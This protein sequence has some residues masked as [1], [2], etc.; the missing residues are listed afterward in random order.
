MTVSYAVDRALWG[1]SSFG[2]HLT[3]F[4]LH[5]IV[6]GLFYGVCTRALSDVG[7]PALAAM[8]L[9]RGKDRGRTGVKPGSNP[10]QTWVRAGSDLGMTP[11][12]PAF[13]AAAGFALHPLMGSAVNYISAR[14]ELLGALGMLACLTFARRAIVASNTTASVMAVAFGIFALTASVSA[15]ALPLL[16]LAYDAWILR[17][18][19]WRRRA[20][21]VY[22]PVFAATAI[23]A[24]W[25]LPA[26]LAA[27]RVP[28]RGLAGNALTEAVVIWRYAGLL[29]VPYGQALI[30][31]VRWVTTPLDP[32]GLLALPVLSAALAGAVHIRKTQP[33]VAFGVAWFLG[34]LAP[35][36][37]VIPLSDAMAEHRV[38]IAGAG[39][40]LAA[41]SALA[42]PLA[43]RR[44]AR[45]IATA[46]LVLLAVHTYRRILLW[47]DPIKLWQESIERAPD[48]WQARLGYADLLREVGRCDQARLEYEVVLRLYPNHAGATAGLTACRGGS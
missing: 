17:D 37:S 23:A 6:V 30:H 32:V 47:S 8:R 40:F 34:V 12:W 35:T 38:Y 14:G 3:N 13:F 24:A 9:R 4:V 48:A 5:T 41:A 33:L 11:E 39:L 31:Q 43:T 2:F 45:A 10:G 15:L 22:L 19:S 7:S 42:S 18:P 36:S 27:D 46:V 20:I 44:L 25:H 1:F 16:I 26:L 28:P 21:R 29:V